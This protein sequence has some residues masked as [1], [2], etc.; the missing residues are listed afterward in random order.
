MAILHESES[1]LGLVI[2]VSHLFSLATSSLAN[3]KGC[4]T[5]NQQRFYL[6]EFKAN[7]K[8]TRSS[9]TYNMCMFV[10]VCARV[11]GSHFSN[12]NSIE[13]NSK[14]LVLDILRGC[15]GKINQS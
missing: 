14:N 7:A 12:I 10:C 15:Q 1:H 2:Q 3:G 6:V 5:A 11:L 9:H 13:Y 8:W 4:L